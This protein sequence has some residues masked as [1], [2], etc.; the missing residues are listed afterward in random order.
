MDAKI[1]NFLDCTFNLD[2]NTFYP[3]KKENSELLYI[4]A[5]S[6]HPPC[7]KKQLPTMIQQRLSDLSSSKAQFDKTK[8]N[9]EKALKESGFNNTLQYNKRTPRS[10]NRSRH[11]TWFNPPFNSA[12]TT[13]IG[14][15]FLTLIEKHF[16][17]HSKYSKIFNRNSVKL[18]YSCTPNIKSIITSHNKS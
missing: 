11:V 18:S 17:R 5:E 13:D 3:Y 6:N 12:V 4:N 2:S 9:Y 10:K 16:P 1:A 15:Q 7:I 14:K 8:A